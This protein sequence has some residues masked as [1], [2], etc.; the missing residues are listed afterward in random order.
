ARPR[1]TATAITA[2]VISSGKIRNRD[3]RVAEGSTGGGSGDR[4]SVEL[5]VSV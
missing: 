2:K 1:T 4:V 5:S 3:L